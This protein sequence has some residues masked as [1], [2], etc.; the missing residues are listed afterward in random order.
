VDGVVDMV[1]WDRPGFSE[2]LL[3]TGW[4]PE[5][6]EVG[7]HLREAPWGLGPKAPLAGG[8]ARV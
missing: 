8:V 7:P 5:E 6:T 4:S 1:G 2:R 3:E